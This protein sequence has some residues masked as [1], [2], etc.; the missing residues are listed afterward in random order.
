MK[1]Y[2][3][4]FETLTHV[5]GHP[6]KLVVNLD[7]RHMVEFTEPN[8]YGDRL[9]LDI[10]FCELTYKK[11][12]SGDY[13]HKEGYI[14]DRPAAYWHFDD[15]I[16]QSPEAGGRSHRSHEVNPTYKP[17][18]GGYVVNFDYIKEATPESLLSTLC[19]IVNNFYTA[20]YTR[21]TW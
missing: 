5:N 7:R 13:W 8:A 15:E 2:A 4:I 3:E 11:G 18:G 14:K 19:E 12:Y 21:P 10:S 17:G 16:T 20:A 9:T 6:L 1:T